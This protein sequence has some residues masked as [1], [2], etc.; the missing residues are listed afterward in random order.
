MSCALG[1]GVA[2]GVLGARHRAVHLEVRAVHVGDRGLQ[3]GVLDDDPVPALA[4][5]AGRRLQGDLQALLDDR[6]IDRLVEVEALAHGAGRGEHLV[7]RQVQLHGA[8][9]GRQG[10]VDERSGDHRRR[11]ARRRRRPHEPAGE[12]Q[13]ARHGHVHRAARRRRAAQGDAQRARRRAVRRGRL[14]LRRSRLLVVQRDGERRADGRRRAGRA[15]RGEP[16]HADERRHHA[17]RPA[18]RLGLAGAARARD[19]GGPRPRPRRRHPDRPRRRHPLR[20]PRRPRCRCARCTGG[21]CR[22]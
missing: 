10:C 1:A 6:P 2:L 11:R 17:P 19:R 15:T 20:P 8:E 18:G 22:T 16:E 7:G 21:S 9:L 5:R 14:V 12:A 13:R 3:L 4:V